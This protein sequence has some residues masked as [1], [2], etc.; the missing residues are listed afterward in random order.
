MAT[1]LKTSDGEKKKKSSID[2]RQEN[3]APHLLDVSDLGTRNNTRSASKLS[4]GRRRN[5]LN[6]TA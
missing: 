2:I 3:T 1:I 5:V 4:S 6:T